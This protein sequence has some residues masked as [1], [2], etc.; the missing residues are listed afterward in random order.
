MLEPIWNQNGFHRMLLPKLPR[1]PTLTRVRPHVES[2]TST[3]RRT[4]E[5]LTVSPQ[6][7]PGSRMSRSPTA[8]RFAPPTTAQHSCA[9][10]LALLTAK[11]R[12]RR[13]CAILEYSD[14][15]S[16]NGTVRISVRPLWDIGEVLPRPCE[17]SAWRRNVPCAKRSAN[18]APRR[19]ETPAGRSGHM[20]RKR[21]TIFGPVRAVTRTQTPHRGRT[22]RF[23]DSTRVERVSAATTSRSVA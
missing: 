1:W 16:M 23:S 5:P 18:V 19:S 12:S 11:Q 13:R 4:C 3:S 21:P 9:W 8:L 6:R 17:P 7:Q 20:P 14:D 10:F 2:R 15:P 22:L